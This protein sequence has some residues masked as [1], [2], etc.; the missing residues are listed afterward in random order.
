MK[1]ILSKKSNNEHNDINNLQ[2]NLLKFRG[3]KNSY[4]YIHITDK[5]EYSYSLLDNVQEA[6]KCLL[7]HIEKG[8]NIFTIADSDTDGI[9]SFSELY[10]YLTSSFEGIKLNYAIHTGKQH[11]I[12]DD[13][14]IPE[15]TNLLIVTDASSNDYKQHK[16]LREQGVD[17]IIID[18]HEADK[19]SE[20]AIVI[21]NQLCDYPNKNLC[22]SAMVYK[23]LQALDEELWQNKADDYLDLVALGLIGDSMNI[24][25][26]ET[27]LYIEK[28]LNNIKNKQFKSLLKKQ[29]YSTKGLININNIAF[30]IAPLINAMIRIGK[31]DEKELMYKGFIEEYSEFD[32]KPKG[33]KPMT[34]E[35]IYTRVGRLCG[36]TK[37]R[38][39]KLRDKALIE[40]SEVIETKNKLNDKV[41]I[42]NCNNKYHLGLTGVVAIK[43]A[44]KYN[45][46]CVLLNKINDGTYRGSGR[47]TDKND[48]KD[49]KLLLN[50]TKLFKGEGHPQAMG[51][52]ID[53]DIPTAIN[54]LN[55]KLKD[56]EFSN[57]TYYVDFI[58]PFEELEDELIFQIELLKSLWGKGLDEP[59]ITITNVEIKASEIEVIGKKSDT[60]K[61]SIDGIEFIKFKIDDDDKLVKETSS[62]TD[63][64][65]KIFKLDIV[66]KCSSNEWNG[67][68]TPQILIEDYNI[69]EIN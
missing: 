52:F 13:I 9:C 45:R 46:P 65:D 54:V 37:S 7:N 55:E 20:N 30:Y 28:G 40:L 22:G 34:K 67:I 27:K 58:I 41:L 48:V 8:S 56:V 10:L 29:E 43:I 31:Q 63:S 64:E 69:V 21:N 44:S 66:G 35:D 61:L 1:Y 11:G 6:V 47:N 19:I 23:F 25:E 50:D 38:Q 4:D 59:I 39:D 33:D 18:H 26:M 49:L 60:L 68:K 17:I 12:S 62:W 53:N 3:V 14:V 57:S 15:N 36:N 24:S 51:V 32:Y 42:I 5:Y 16:E 2:D